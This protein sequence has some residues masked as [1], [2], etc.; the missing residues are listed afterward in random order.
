[1]QEDFPA[2]GCDFVQSPT[3]ER[4]LQEIW[5]PAMLEDQLDQLRRE[6]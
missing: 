1:M 4:G 6:V 3:G 2:V 5:R